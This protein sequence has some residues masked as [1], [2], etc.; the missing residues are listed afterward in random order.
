MHADNRKFCLFS[1]LSKQVEVRG[2]P[3]P[4]VLPP[5]PV[6]ATP[7]RDLPGRAALTAEWGQGPCRCVSPAAS[8]HLSLCTVTQSA[9]K[10]CCHSCCFSIA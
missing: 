7:S 3:S 10:T 6:T 5:A 9:L 4:S 1:G 2:Q 8:R